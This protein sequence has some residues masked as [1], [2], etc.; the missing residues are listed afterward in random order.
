MPGDLVAGP[1]GHAPIVSRRG[2]DVVVVASK[3]KNTRPDQRAG[4]SLERV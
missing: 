2:G 3:E 4:T 1:E